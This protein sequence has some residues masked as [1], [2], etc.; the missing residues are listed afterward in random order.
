MRG[1][2]CEV[3]DPRCYAEGIRRKVPGARPNVPD[4]RCRDGP[5]MARRRRR[6]AATGPRRRGAARGGLVAGSRQSLNKWAMV[7]EG[8]E[9][10]W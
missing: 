6:G 8:L 10:V 1:E 2:R 7:L 4:A 5:A 3:P 9:I